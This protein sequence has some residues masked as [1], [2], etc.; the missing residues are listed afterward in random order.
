MNSKN[1]LK[2]C[3]FIM[4][5][6]WSVSCISQPNNKEAAM[7]NNGIINRKPVV[8][9]QFYPAKPDELNANLIKLFAEASPGKTK[10][11]V[12]TII[13]PHA[14]YV[15]SGEVAASSFNQINPKKK[16]NTIFVI[17][18]SHRIMFDGASIYNKGNYETP[19]GEVKVD[20]ETANLLI[21]NYNVFKFKAEAHDYEHCLEVQLPF[22]QHVMET[23]FKIVP[24][25][26]ATQNSRTCIKIADALKPYF[27]DDNLFVI[28]TDFSH[29]PAYK[30]AVTVDNLTAQAIIS[31]KPEALISTLSNNEKMGIN[32]LA[33]SLCGWTSVLTLLYMTYDKHDI[34]YFPI[35]Y[36]NSG[37]SKYYGDKSRVVGYYSIA[38]SSTVDV[39]L[40]E[41]KKQKDNTGFD[42]SKEDKK[43]L[44]EISRKT[45][46]SYIKSGK[47]SPVNESS[48]PEILKTNCGAF[49]SLHIGKDLRGCIGNFAQDIP[50]YKTVQEMTVAS[51]S[52]DYR[53]PPV[54]EDELKKID[55]EISVLTPLQK[56][57][58]INEIQL[59][60]H[61]IY[62]K[63]GSGTGTF[64]PQVAT[65][66]GWTL[67]EFLGHCARDKASIGWEGWKDAEL[68]T[69]EA[70]V[71]SEHEMK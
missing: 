51:S 62:M 50:L 49:V 21:N 47:V 43:K 71:F 24:I 59:G 57:S 33:T 8:A 52:R 22:L 65:M 68:Y 16:Y 28:S 46:E 55:I 41:D 23:D 25:V 13:S 63:K 32:D 69:Y 67:E 18:S 56:I 20:L 1:K 36:K 11:N 60:K 17:G 12:R 34:K 31:N 66:T 42:L 29:Y 27:T 19:L 38:V 53:F 10:G 2:C 40:K 45:L 30:D 70:I 3:L 35:A 9:G 6:I 39:E 26:I 64:L 14:G 15:F 58:S 61:G 5:F 7:Q 54:S 4:Q 37:D 44:L 48:L